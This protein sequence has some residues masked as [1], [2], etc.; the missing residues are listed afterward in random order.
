MSGL[1][2]S[3]LYV[4]YDGQL[5]RGR[6]RVV[7]E[8][9]RDR[10]AVL[11]VLEPLP[12]RLR[13]ALRDAAVLLARRRC[14]GLTIRAAVVDRDDGARS[15]TQ[16]VSVSTS[17]TARCEPNGNDEPS[18]LKSSSAPR[19][20]V[21]V[22]RRLGGS[23]TPATTVAVGNARD[24][25]QPSSPT[26]MSSGRPRAGAPRARFACVEHLL[27]RG[28]ERAAADLQRPRPA[29]AAAAWHGRGVGVDERA[30]APSGRR[31]CRR[32]SSRTSSRGPGRAP[33]CRPDRDRAVVVDLDRAEL[34]GAYRRVISRY[35]ATPIPSST[36]SPASRRRRCSARSASY[37]PMRSDL[38]ERLVV[39][40][41]VVRRA[42]RRRRT[43]TRRA[44]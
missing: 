39:L 38:A 13:D 34:A 16:P 27:G 22:G 8:V 25:D 2:V 28:A 14:S 20:V 17:T 37:P 9:R 4:S 15:S 7:D 40:A 26:T 35:D 23:S 44:G 42:G 5:G 10:V 29:G 36:G 41:G 31:A 11:V 21:L 18:D 33:T 32:R 24:P 43:G 12:Q 3:V 6:H 30:R 19:R 1:G